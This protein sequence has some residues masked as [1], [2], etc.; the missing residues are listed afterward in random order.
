MRKAYSKPEIF[1]EDFSLTTNITAGCEYIANATENKCGY[2][3]ANSGIVVCADTAYC[4][5]TQGVTD[6]KSYNGVCYNNPSDSNN[7]FSSY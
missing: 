4:T 5:Y 2:S 3:V 7:L 1:F 6:D